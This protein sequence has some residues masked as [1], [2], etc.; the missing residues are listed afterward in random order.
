MKFRNYL[1]NNR[2][3]NAKTLV[4]MIKGD[5]SE[6]SKSED[7]NKIPHSNEVTTSPIYSHPLQTYS[8]TTK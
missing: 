6:G 8:D 7:L 5:K 4:Q 1:E 2:P 3:A